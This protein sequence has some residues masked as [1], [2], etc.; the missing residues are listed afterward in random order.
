MNSPDWNNSFP[1][2]KSNRNF[3][4]SLQRALMFCC[5]YIN[6]TERCSHFSETGSRELSGFTCCQMQPRPNTWEPQ[7]SFGNY[8]LRS[9]G[10]SCTLLFSSP[11]IG[12]D[13]SKNKTKWNQNQQAKKKSPKD[14]KQK[15][16]PRSKPAD[17]INDLASELL[18]YNPT[19]PHSLLFQPSP[20]L[21]PDL[22]PYIKLLSCTFN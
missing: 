17:G 13:L 2:T 20:P 6:N 14:K 21:P 11:R 19:S 9:K 7:S 4:W 18:V 12:K 10:L 8:Y 15:P 16:K 5:L 3:F 1:K 22:Y